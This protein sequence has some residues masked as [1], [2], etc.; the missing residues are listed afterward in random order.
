MVIT[1][2]VQVSPR[3]MGLGRDVAAPTTINE[4]TL[5]PFK[6]Y[7]AAIHGERSTSD[8]FRRRPLAV[9]QICHTGR[10]SMNFIG[11]RPPFVSPLAPSAVPMELKAKRGRAVPLLGHIARGLLFRTALAMT[12]NQVD[13]AVGEF[14]KTAVLAAKA[15][16]DGVQLHAAHGCK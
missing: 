9:M 14:V 4:L 5:A 1:G 11:G 8:D 3:H 7:A 12:P 2:N 13:E 6:K 15:G 16:F 10:Q